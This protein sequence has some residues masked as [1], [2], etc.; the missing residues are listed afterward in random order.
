MISAILL[1]AGESKR[2]GTPKMLLNWGQETVLGHVISVFGKAGLEDILV[3]T[4]AGSAKIEKM[5]GEMAGA[6]P[7]R[8]VFN[9]VYATGDMLSSIQTGLR[10]LARKGTEAVIIGLGDQPQV[11]ERTV[12]AIL[13]SFKSTSQPLIVPTHQRHRGHPWLVGREFWDE[14]LRMGWSQTP[15]DFL[16]R[17]A[18]EIHYVES[19]S[20]S[21]FADLDTPEDYTRARPD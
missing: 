9:P 18:G 3:V 5:V 15:R 13:N 19:G 10:D 21:I 1:A 14:I 2:M 20:P 6:F 8:S 12:R 17:H 7:A 11:E 4:G 16:N